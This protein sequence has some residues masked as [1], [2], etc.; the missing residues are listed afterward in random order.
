MGRRICILEDD[1]N[2]R[3]IITILLS[4]ENYEVTAYASIADFAARSTEYIPDLFLLDVMLPD[5]SGIDVCGLLKTTQ[6]TMNIPV[7]MM[8][9]NSSKRLIELSCQA[10]GFVPKPFD[11]YELL[12]KVS[13]SFIN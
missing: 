10:D 13:K 12:D 8:S 1:E 9:A 4:E 7:L 6:H 5:G 2:I 11:I 3:E